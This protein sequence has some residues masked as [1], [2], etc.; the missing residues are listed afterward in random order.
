VGGLPEIVTALLDN[1]AV[2]DEL[3][4]AMVGLVRDVV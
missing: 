3:E 1:A 4:P 2:M